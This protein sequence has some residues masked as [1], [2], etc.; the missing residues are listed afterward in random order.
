[1]VF[2]LASD[3]LQDSSRRERW[4]SQENNYPF[5]VCGTIGQNHTGKLQA[6]PGIHLH[7]LTDNINQVYKTPKT[8][9][10]KGADLFIIGRAIY[11]SKEPLR[12][13]ISS[14]IGTDSTTF[15]FNPEFIIQ[16]N[17][18]KIISLSS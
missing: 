3:E 15:Q 8:A 5:P 12:C 1:M 10:E 13:L 18:I 16:L 11:N 7:Q 9:K 14:C 6:T 4:N 17:W 2:L